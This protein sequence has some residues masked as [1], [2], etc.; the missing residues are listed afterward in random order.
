VGKPLA[1]SIRQHYLSLR[2]DENYLRFVIHEGAIRA[3]AHTDA[4]LSKVYRTV[5]LLD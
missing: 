1:E 5:G 2:E 4:M 3:Q